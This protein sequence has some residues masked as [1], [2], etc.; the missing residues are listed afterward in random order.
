MTEQQSEQ[1]RIAQWLEAKADTMEDWL[2]KQPSFFLQ[3]EDQGHTATYIRALRD[4]ASYLISDL[5]K[6]MRAP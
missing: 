1:R 2:R 6:G 4:V 5:T 3:Y